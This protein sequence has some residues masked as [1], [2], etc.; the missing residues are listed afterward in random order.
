VDTEKLNNNT[1][2]E[3]ELDH[4]ASGKER[5]NLDKIVGNAWKVK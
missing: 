5:G 1:I 4:V 3:D 2:Q